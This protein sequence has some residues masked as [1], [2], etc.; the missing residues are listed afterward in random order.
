M[1]NGNEQ[2][3]RLMICVFNG[4]CHF[5]CFMTDITIPRPKCRA[6][7]GPTAKEP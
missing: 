2:I 1:S 6:P 4:Y 5:V 3:Y 7:L